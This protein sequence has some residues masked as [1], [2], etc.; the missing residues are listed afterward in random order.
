MRDARRPQLRSRT[1][2][3]ARDV[4][5]A[6]VL[7]IA[8]YGMARLLWEAQAVLFVAFLGVLL[9]LPLAAA[10]DY[11]S[12]WRVPR[13]VA[14]MAIMVVSVAL[15]ARV[16]AG[17]APT[18]RSELRE[19]RQRLPEAIDRVEGWLAS[20]QQGV[21]GAVL[22]IQDTLTAP[23]TTDA[24]RAA[25]PRDTVPVIA[26]DTASRAALRDRLIEQA[27][28]ATR[29]LFPFLSSTIAVVGGLL[30]VLVIAVY[31][32]VE[33][34]T[35]VGGILKLVP[36]RSRERAG[37]VLNA[38]TATLRRWML[39]QLVAMVAIG[40]LTTLVL[41][42]LDVRAAIAL[43][44]LAGLLEFIP[45]FGPII[46]ALPGV[47]MGFLDSPEKALWVALAY[48]AIQQ[49]ESQLL[50]PLLM[51]GAIALPPVVTIVS[52]TTMAVVFGFLG[53]MI[54]VPLTAVVIVAV[55]LLYVEGV[56]GEEVEV[57][58]RDNEPADAITNTNRTS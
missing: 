53:L 49:A 41:Q 5:R 14:A 21:V 1:A 12:R 47:A 37:E 7:V 46:A 13:G 22:G 48:I 55:K 2:W 3:T 10:V 4:V 36:Q 16:V 50:T 28:G 18:L 34:D 26:S 32:A 44:V 19:L 54:A 40:L 39:T 20:Q 31:V 15:M 23:D 27:R 11:L 33:P 56:V 42:L 25:P 17:L 57:L 6:A 29:F 9:G 51:K 43:G 8:L 58:G 45:T 52:Q 24:A 30:L 35:Y 38:I